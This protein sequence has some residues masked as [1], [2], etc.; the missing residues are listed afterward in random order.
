MYTICIASKFNV[1]LSQRYIKKRH[2]FKLICLIFFGV[3]TLKELVTYLIFFRYSKTHPKPHELSRPFWPG[4]SAG[5]QLQSQYEPD[6]VRSIGDVSR[7]YGTRETSQHEHNARVSIHTSWWSLSHNRDWPL[8]PQPG[9]HVRS[10][11]QQ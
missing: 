10:S 9:L 2:K 5:V 8:Q 11:K 7:E 1:L 4:S 3:L 6:R